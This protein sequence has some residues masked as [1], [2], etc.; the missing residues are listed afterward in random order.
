MEL[1][2]ARA[3]PQLCALYATHACALGL[4]GV[5]LS[6][7]LKAHG[8]E[9][10]VPYAYACGST[11]ALLSPLAV[12]ALADQRMAPERVLRL[13]GM[14][15]IVC[16]LLLNTAI[17]RG[18]GAGWVL[19][20]AQAHALWSAPTFGLSTS[21]IF[22][23]LERAKEEFGPVRI[24][25]TI[26]WMGAG[27]IISWVLRA[28]DSVISGYA[29]CVAWALTVA[30]TYTLPK[31]QR[32]SLPKPKRTFTEILGLD[33]LPL[34]AHPDH[35]VVFITAALLNMSLAA[36]YPFTVLHLE[37]LGVRQVTVAM[38]LGQITEIVAMLALSRLLTRWRLKWVFLAGIGF[39]TLRYAAFMLD[40]TPAVFAGIFL[41]GLCYT[42]FFITAQIYL[43]QRIVV[44]MRARAQ[45]L[46]TLMTSGLGS[47]CGTLGTGWWR[48]MCQN[49]G[50]TQWPRFWGGMTAVTLAV[51]V[52]F[53]VAYRG[54][55][56]SD[57]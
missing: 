44:A 12:G 49:S 31:S 35:R 54:R 19:V 37:D 24:W 9:S 55:E 13:M 36:F 1:T 56:R 41:H 15:A 5:N 30:L 39:G 43:E 47:L 27:G 52:F 22:S 11:A 8:L 6:N 29:A 10:I 4:W 45:A 42:L 50:T 33:A 20:F 28:D 32:L 38:S 34:L 2:R 57:T 16:L 21:L 53:A 14:G 48:Q 46:L 40:S 3:K 26:G 17:E 7:V 23:R 51:F 25:A 18:W